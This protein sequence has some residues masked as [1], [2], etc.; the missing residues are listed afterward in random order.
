VRETLARLPSW[1]TLSNSEKTDNNHEFTPVNM[2]PI[3]EPDCA[4]ASFNKGCWMTEYCGVGLSRY[5]YYPCGTGTAIDRVYGFDVSLKRLSALTEP[6]L[7]RQLDRLC[8][9]CGF[10]ATNYRLDIATTEMISASWQAALARYQKR[11]PRLEEY[12]PS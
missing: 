11:R 9:Y 6:A 12:G 1:V 3:D 10:F 2:A 4:D 5:G 8:R 7:R